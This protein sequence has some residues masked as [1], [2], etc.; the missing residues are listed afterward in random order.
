MKNMEKRECLFEREV[1]LYTVFLSPFSSAVRR[2]NFL[3]R[4]LVEFTKIVSTDFPR[5]VIFLSPSPSF[6]REVISVS[7]LHGSLE[8]ERRLEL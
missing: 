6:L 5:E 1:E 3:K 8:I 4:I 2:K 7:S